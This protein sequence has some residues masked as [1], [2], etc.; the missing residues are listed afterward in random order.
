MAKLCLKLENFNFD[1]V[2]PI[3]VNEITC[4]AGETD[5]YVAESLKIE[6]ERMFARKKTNT[7]L[8][9]NCEYVFSTLTYV[10]VS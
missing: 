2:D 9:Y 4:K 8:T 10:F 5:P 1:F 3:Y 6:F 7:L